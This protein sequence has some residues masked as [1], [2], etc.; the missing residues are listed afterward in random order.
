M[1]PVPKAARIDLQL[2]YELF[3]ARTIPLHSGELACREKTGAELCD[4]KRGST[5]DAE[6]VPVRSAVQCQKGCVFYNAC[7]VQGAMHRHDRLAWQR[8]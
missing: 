3:G 8:P 7:K 4:A 1:H 5:E 6:I 2:D